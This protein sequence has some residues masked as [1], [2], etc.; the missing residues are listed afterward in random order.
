VI[1]PAGTLLTEDEVEKI[2]ALGID[3][4]KVR[5]ALTCD[6]RYGICAKC[7]GRDLVVAS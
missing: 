4:V 2:D 7:Y 1:Y 5:T 6:T 3:E